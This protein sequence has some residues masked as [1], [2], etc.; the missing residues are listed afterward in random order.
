MCGCNVGVVGDWYFRW[1]LGEC[2]GLYGGVGTGILVF[3]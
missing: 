2:L 3:V 1:L